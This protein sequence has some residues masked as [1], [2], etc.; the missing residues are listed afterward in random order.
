MGKSQRIKGQIGERE[1]AKILTDE[2]GQCIQRKLGAARDGGD[3]LEVG[4]FSI[5]C[6]RQETIKADLW[7]EQAIISAQQT[8]KIPIVVYRKSR[9]PW[10]VIIS[11]AD[12][13]P[14]MR[15]EL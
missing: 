15:G 10:R 3:D 4:P 5:E 7:M 6:K 13:I 1:L 14:L 9:T 2:L 12:F 11:L 8:Q